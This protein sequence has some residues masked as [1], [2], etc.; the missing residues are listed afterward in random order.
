MWL[1]AS[2]VYHSAHGRV[3]FAD[4]IQFLGSIVRNVQH[5][6]TSVVRLDRQFLTEAKSS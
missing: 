3:N 6:R 4:I 2:D 5:S 1:G